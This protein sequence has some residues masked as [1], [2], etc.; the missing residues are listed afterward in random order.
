MDGGLEIIGWGAAWPNQTFATMNVHHVETGTT[1]GDKVFWNC[2]NSN[3][4]CLVPGDSGGAGFKKLNSTWFQATIFAGGS[5]TPGVTPD[6]F[7]LSTATPSVRAFLD[8]NLH[9][10]PINSA[11]VGAF[12]GVQVS[13]RGVNALDIFWLY[14]GSLMTQAYN[15]GWGSS[16]SL[17]KPSGKTLAGK[18]ASVSWSSSRVDVFVRATDNTLWQIYYNGAVWSA[19]TQIANVNITASPAVSSWGANRLDLFYRGSNGNL[20]HH[21]YS[22]GW[23]GRGSPEDL[24]GGILGGPAAV[25][26]GSGLIDIVARG[27]DNYLYHRFYPS[28][29]FFSSFAW[30]NSPQTYHDPAI[31]SWSPNR[32]DIY[33]VDSS[34]NL[35][36]L[37]FEDGNWLDAWIN[38]GIVAPLCALS[39][40]SWGPG[41]L[42]L[43][44]CASGS[45]WQTYFPRP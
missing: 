31:A 21:Y 15:S 32:L 1:V 33:A 2:N 3:P 14:S 19:W 37:W 44:S 28:G 17:G 40:A 38:T 43:F 16:Y 29:G 27:T 18:P 8:K 36:H 41:R 5:G 42:D 9:T 25:S 45:T 7:S 4:T 24:G 10:S 20:W 34:Q 35:H 22:S 12:D 23:A 6:T 30:L 11:N 26:R 39:A 13:K